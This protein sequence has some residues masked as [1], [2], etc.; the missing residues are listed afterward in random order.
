VIATKLQKIV[1]YNQLQ[2]FYPPAR[3]QQVVAQVASRV[4]FDALAAR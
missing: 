4:D 1:D 3:L 2:A